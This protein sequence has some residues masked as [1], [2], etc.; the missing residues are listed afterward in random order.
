MAARQLGHNSCIKVK[1]GPCC[2]WDNQAPLNKSLIN[3]ID[4]SYKWIY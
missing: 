4:N 3:M 2:T 1:P